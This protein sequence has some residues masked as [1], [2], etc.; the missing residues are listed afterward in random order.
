MVRHLRAELVARAYAT[1]AAAAVIP[2]VAHGAVGDAGHVRVGGVFAGVGGRLFDD[3]NV[4]LHDFLVGVRLDDL[5]VGVRSHD[6]RGE[7]QALASGGS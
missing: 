6:I 4:R 2:A 1:G 3:L 7:V 5:L